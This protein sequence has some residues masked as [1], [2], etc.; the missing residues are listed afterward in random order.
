MSMLPKK[1]ELAQRQP[2]AMLL[3]LLPLPLL[4]VL[5]G[6][7]VDGQVLGALT[8]AGV[9]A[10]F[11]TGAALVRRGLVQELFLQQ[12]R[13]IVNTPTPLKLIGSA[14]VGAA[15]FC[16]AWLLGGSSLLEAVGYAAG[17]LGGSLMFYGFDERPKV[18][19][20]EVEGQADVV[21]ALA[22]AEQKVLA[23]EQANVGIECVELTDRLNRITAQARQVI[24]VLAEKP[25][26]L[27][28]AR[29]FL[30]T[31]L[32]GAESVAE[33]YA[34]THQRTD[35]SE[36]D[37]SFRQVLVTIEDVFKEQYDKLLE[38]DVLDLDVQIEVLKTQLE[39]EGVS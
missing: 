7:I 27:R 3:F 24:D 38:D 30:S 17:A 21:K 20:A 14:L 34:K 26:K 13:H 29:R 12:R 10:G 16:T 15:T 23:I 1:A 33:G 25:D 5:L 35:S 2:K 32:N 31:Y 22:Q 11:Y 8:S 39:R 36:L 6:Q 37:D 28:R 18:R 9:L 19:V 4:A